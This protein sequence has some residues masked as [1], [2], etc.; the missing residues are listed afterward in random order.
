LVDCY[1][2]RGCGVGQELIFVCDGAAWIWKLI[3]HYFPEA[4]QIV[5]WYHTV[6]YLTPIAEAAFSQENQRKQWRQKVRDW[7][8]HGRIQKV[9]QACQQYLDHPLAAEAAQRAVTYY[10]NNQQRMDYAYYRQQGYWIGSGTVESACKQIATARLKIS[11][12]RWTLSGAIATAKAR[13]A[14]L[15]HGD[16]FDTLSRLPLAV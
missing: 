4:I 15:S 16:G 8:W 9:I 1:G 7:L 2:P 3:A 14:W 12:A 10:T 6:A 11:G 5:D 13:A